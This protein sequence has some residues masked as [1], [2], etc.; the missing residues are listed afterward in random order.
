[1]PA[2]PDFH[3]R[4]HPLHGVLQV[5]SQPT[6]V[7]DTV[8]TKDRQRWLACDAVHEL[9]REVWRDARVWRLGRYV[10]MPD[11][12]HFFAGATQSSTEYDAW[13]KFWKSQFSKRF[14]HSACRWQ[15][16]HWDTRIRNAAAYEEKWLYVR[17][18]PVRHGLV[19]RPED[20]PY[21][22]ELHALRWE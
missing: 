21:S 7:F 3:Q 11:H 17:N 18:N 14:K 16:D 9:L 19:S 1:M 13:V 20:W 22:G 10:V 6:I 2:E 4:K 5:E 15:T 8:C 12:I